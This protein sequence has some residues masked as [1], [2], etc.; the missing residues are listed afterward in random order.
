MKAPDEVARLMALAA[1]DASYHA[2][3][4]RAIWE[5]VLWFPIQYHPELG[6]PYEPQAEEIPFWVGE[7]EL[8]PFVPLFSSPKLMRLGLARFA[9]RH[10]RARMPARELFSRLIERGHAVRLNPEAEVQ[11]S[12]TVELMQDLVAG[13]MLAMLEE[14]KR[15]ARG[16]VEPLPPEEW[17]EAWRERLRLEAEE[18]P[19]LIALWL[20]RA[21]EMSDGSPLDAVHLV[22]WVRDIEH[23]AIGNVRRAAELAF[24]GRRLE[25]MYLDEAGHAEAVAAMRAYPPVFPL[26]AKA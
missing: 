10:T 18:Q 13:N 24:A 11:G 25:W 8:G 2:A 4:M 17:P 26:A 1:R 19:G 12:M 7:D 16:T 6:D 22:A 15:T 5:A 9:Q 14:G 3:S 20:C 23:T 21:V